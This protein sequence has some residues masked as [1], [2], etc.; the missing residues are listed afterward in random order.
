MD[1]NKVFFVVF[2]GRKKNFCGTKTD[3]YDTPGQIQRS[4]SQKKTGTLLAKS[5]HSISLRLF[6]TKKK[7]MTGLVL[8]SKMEN[9]TL[10]VTCLPLVQLIVMPPYQKKTPK[11][12]RLLGH[13]LCRFMG[14][15]AIHEMPG[16]NPPRKSQNRPWFTM[17][18]WFPKSGWEQNELEGFSP[19]PIC[20]K[21][22]AS[23]IWIKTSQKFG[24]KIPKI[25]Q[26]PPP[27]KAEVGCFFPQL[28]QTKWIFRWIQ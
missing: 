25:C 4:P 17:G 27:R 28:A 8:F 20:K 13:L 6:H 7:W 26:L 9:S 5:C 16:G 10:H 19:P 24:V 11:K 12:N 2:F 18:F 22:A 23:Q 21:Y 15:I 3:P 14:F 1:M